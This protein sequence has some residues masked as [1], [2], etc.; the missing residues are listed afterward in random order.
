[1]CK[2]IC[3]DV[4]IHWENFARQSDDS[5]A[6]KVV[7]FFGGKTARL[8]TPTRV[9]ADTLHAVILSTWML[10]PNSFSACYSRDIFASFF[11]IENEFSGQITHFYA[12]IVSVATGILN[13]NLLCAFPRKKPKRHIRNQTHEI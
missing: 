1:M 4:P 6:T 13:K 5:A 3:V 11:Q 7:Q 8:A 2:T 9:S 10:S 12:F